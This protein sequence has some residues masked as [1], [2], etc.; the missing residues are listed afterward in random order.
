[1]EMLPYFRAS[2]GVSEENID[3]AEKTLNVQF[4]SEYRSYL[5]KY[6]TVSVDGHELTGIHSSK[7]LNVVDVTILEKDR[8]SDIPENWYV[9]E[10]ANIDNIVIWQN[11]RG[12]IFQTCP[13]NEPIKIANSI[14]EY[15]SLDE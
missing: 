2:D 6:G 12:E 11:E 15:L 1:M 14:V 10:Q 7:R 4:A 8:N 9:L 13:G 3:K 5:T